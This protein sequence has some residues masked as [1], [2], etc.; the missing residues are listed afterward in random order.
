MKT[1]GECLAGKVSR[2]KALVALEL[3]LIAGCLLQYLVPLHQYSYQGK[4]LTASVCR[5]LEYSDNNNLGCYVDEALIPDGIDPHSIYITTPFVDLPKGSYR[6]SIVYSTDDADQKYAFTSEYRLDSVV[7]GHNGNRIPM[8]SGSVEHSF[9]SPIRADEFQVHVDYS[10]SGYLFVESITIS[11]TNAWKNILLFY[12]LLFSLFIDGIILCYRGL[13]EYSRRRARVTWAALIGLVL[14]VS[15]PVMNF[16]MLRGDDLLFHLNRI[17]G[18]KTSLLAGQF[19]NRVSTHW[20]KGYGYAS[21]VLYGEAFLYIPALLRIM[22]FSVQGAYK[23]YVVLINLATVIVAYYSF[24]KVFHNDK[25][26]LA[27]TMVYALAPYRLV[28]IYM[29]AAVGEYTAMLFFP[30]IFCGLMQIYFENTQDDSYKYNCIPLILGFTGIIQSHVISSVIAAGFT[31]LFCLVFIRRTFCPARLIRMIKAAAG[32]I[33]LNLWF[34]VPF[35]DYFHL[36][37]TKR[38]D[39]T[40]ILGRM[41]SHGAFLSQMFTLFQRGAARAYTTIEGMGTT[42]ERN[43]A[44]G[45]LAFAAAFY[46]LYRLYHGK[47]QSKIAKIGDCS[48]AFAMLSGFMCTIWF[49]WSFFQQMNGLFRFVVKNIQFPWR[50]MGVTCLFLTV[51]TICLVCLLESEKDKRLYYAILVLIGGFFIVSADYYMYDYTQTAE[52]HRYEDEAQVATTEIGVGEYLP[53]DT[54][55]NFL[56]NTESIPGDGVEVSGECNMG[57]GR[58]VTC[59]NTGEEDAC[60][61][62]PLLPYRGYVCRDEETGEKLK[63][64][65]DI[66]GKVRVMVPAGYTGTFYVK[67]EEPWYWRAAEVISLLTFLTGAVWAVVKRK[68]A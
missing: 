51:T 40:G 37:Y 32:V 14:F 33:L 23:L 34:L 50:F 16:F 19:P 7:T 5:Y 6:V 8:D 2:F 45:G 52:L 44:L 38:P 39:V 48:L 1:Y 66:P 46:F 43:Y 4:D 13:P 60:I 11:E 30:L 28:C 58:T 47:T 29:R 49:P 17:E 36:G 18:I 67:Y 63:I 21:A 3:F 10:G 57:D 56:D 22:G 68:Q 42:D 62:L 20:N 24:R 61:D 12:V 31:A 9:F 59:R 15:I 54:P 64:Q 27:G 35:L 26:A 53:G 25:A 41:N 65:L 55:E